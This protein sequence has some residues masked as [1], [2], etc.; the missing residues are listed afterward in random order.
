MPS[1]GIYLNGKTYALAH[2]LGGNH[3]RER[4]IWS[5]AIGSIL[6]FSSRGKRCRPMPSV[7]LPIPAIISV[8]PNQ[9]V[10]DISAHFS[11]SAK[12]AVDFAFELAS[13]F[14]HEQVEPLHFFIGSMEDENVSVVFG[15]LGVSVDLLKDAMR[16]RLETRTLGKPTLVC[17]IAQTVLLEAFRS[18][19]ARSRSQVSALEI[20]AASYQQDIF[21]QQM[22]FERGVDSQRFCNMIEWLRIHESEQERYERFQNLNSR[23][24]VNLRTRAVRSHFTPNLDD[25]SQ[26]LTADVCEGRFPMLIDRI[27]ELDEIIELIQ[28]GRQ[29]VVLVG[30]SGVG[31][32]SII[33][34]LAERIVMGQVPKSLLDKHLVRLSLF[35]L[36]ET[37]SPGDAEE[38]MRRVLFEVAR[39]GNIILVISDIDQLVQNQDESDHDPQN[40]LVDFMSRTGICV[41]ATST[42]EAYNAKIERCVLGRAFEKVDVIE[43]DQQIAIH[44]LQ[45]KIGSIEQ[46]C[47]VI[48]SYDAVE[49][50]VAFSDRYIHEEFLPK[51]A[52]EVARETAVRVSQ[53]RGVDA[54][55]T[56][57]DVARIVEQKTG[58]HVPGQT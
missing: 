42:P 31:K 10:V 37:T 18:A 24:S 48:F 50:A 49:S 54:L 21:L 46:D 16:S 36:I 34:G 43:P 41:I 30:P 2:A 3:N 23:R 6:S 8:I 9:I 20:F 35:K 12:R 53:E 57:R 55:V 40:V 13:Q 33:A 25:K 51:K 45:S 47:Q 39:E 11:V 1:L 44:V 22:L 7:E 14:G 5:K 27:S 38:R 32:F 56:E 52:I 58:I 15:R 28:G 29:S 19:L 17:E 4:A 26:D